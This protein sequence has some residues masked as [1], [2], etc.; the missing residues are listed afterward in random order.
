MGGGE[1]VFRKPAKGGG[2]EKRRGFYSQIQAS[3]TPSRRSLV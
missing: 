2:G 3:P 1:G